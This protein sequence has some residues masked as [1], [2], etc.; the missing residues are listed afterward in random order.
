MM[1]TS[2]RL[3]QPGQKVAGF[4]TLE[5]DSLIAD[6]RAICFVRERGARDACTTKFWESP[7]IPVSGGGGAAT[8]DPT[9]GWGLGRRTSNVE[10]QT[11]TVQRRAGNV[12]RSNG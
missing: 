11:P 7:A 4:S 5:H 2:F 9:T 6:R 12:G 10:R 3:A 8:P 1:M